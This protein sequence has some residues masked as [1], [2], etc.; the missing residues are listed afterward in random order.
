MVTFL[1]YGMK[2]QHRRSLRVYTW[3]C[4][5]WSFMWAI[6][7]GLFILM[8]VIQEKQAI[9]DGI[10][11]FLIT[12]LII[13]GPFLA[14][15]FYWQDKVLRSS[16]DLRF[17]DAP[18]YRYSSIWRYLPSPIRYGLTQEYSSGLR[19]YTIAN[20]MYTSI[21]SILIIENG[22]ETYVN[23]ESSG[24][25]IFDLMVMFMGLVIFIFLLIGPVW[26]FQRVGDRKIERISKEVDYWRQYYQAKRMAKGIDLIPAIGPGIEQFGDPGTDP[27]TRTSN[28]SSIHPTSYPFS[29]HLPP[30]PPN[31]QPPVNTT[32]DHQKL[33][34]AANYTKALAY[35]SAARLYEELGMWDDAGRM[36]L[37]D[38]K[39]HAS[40]TIFHV[41]RLNIY[42][43]TVIQNSIITDS[44]V[45][46]D[47]DGL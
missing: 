18:E 26:Y 14:I 33:T 34:M 9:T 23:I 11:T 37:L 22:Y 1:I 36:R 16:G 32:G 27:F 40:R 6:L 44:T 13:A 41:D 20:I 39:A 43:S 47:G 7:W 42:R 29:G 46:G 3:F 19:T 10:V 15:Q 21:M 12:M 2:Q 30:I 31:H 5:V 38:I 17:H 24:S 28:Q 45:G 35:E 25:I 8:N 4:I